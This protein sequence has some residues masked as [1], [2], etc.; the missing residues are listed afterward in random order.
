MLAVSLDTAGEKIV[1]SFVSEFGL[2]FPILLDPSNTVS[3]VY[4]LTGVPET[5]IIGKDGVILVKIIGPQDWT[6][7]EWLDFF[8][9][10]IGRTF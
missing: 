3:G 8:D 2:T 7:K 9:Q 6:K 4:A 10:A 5:F 1:R